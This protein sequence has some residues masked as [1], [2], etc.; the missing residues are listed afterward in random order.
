MLLDERRTLPGTV[1]ADQTFL[2]QVGDQVS[3]GDGLGVMG[4]TGRSD[5]RHLHF[6]LGTY[7]DAFDPCEPSQSMDA[8]YDAENLPFQ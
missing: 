4:N 1:A 7:V 8:V 3:M 2:V 5:E 6:E